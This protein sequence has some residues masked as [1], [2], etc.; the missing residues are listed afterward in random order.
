MILTSSNQREIHIKSQNIEIDN[1]PLKK[2]KSKSRNPQRNH[3]PKINSNI[4][5]I[6]ILITGFLH[7][8]LIL[9]R[10]HNFTITK[11]RKETR[12]R[13]ST[14]LHRTKKELSRPDRRSTNANQC[15]SLGP[16]A[17]LL[18]YWPVTRDCEQCVC[19]GRVTVLRFCE[20][21]KTS[22]GTFAL[23]EHVSWIN[24]THGRLLGYGPSVK[25]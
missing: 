13:W 20:K 9:D 3:S 11:A 10:S 2:S 16:A 12:E 7:R 6:F 15:V 8:N 19:C 17:C 14:A 1:N 23:F 24:F 21:K 22:E 4:V 5:L 25:N 18:G